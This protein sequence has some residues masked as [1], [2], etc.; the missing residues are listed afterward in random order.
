[1]KYILIIFV[2]GVRSA[3][4]ISA[5]F[6]NREACYNAIKVVQEQIQTTA[7]ICVPKG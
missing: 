4:G 6:D 1:M 5:E 7:A 3:S 2:F